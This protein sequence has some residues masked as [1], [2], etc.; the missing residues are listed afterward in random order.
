MNDMIMNKSIIKQCQYNG[1][2]NFQ[3]VRYDT[4]PF[5]WDKN[6]QINTEV[7]SL[8]VFSTSGDILDV[9]NLKNP[10]LIRFPVKG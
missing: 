7:I 8:D 1:E 6:T 5:T 4:N 2:S 3:S 10:V 9:K